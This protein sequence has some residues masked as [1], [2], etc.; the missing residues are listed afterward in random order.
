[1]KPLRLTIEG[2]HSFAQEQQIAF[3][4]LSDLGMFG[5]FGPTGSGKSSILDAITLA[6]YCDIPNG[7][8]GAINHT[9]KRMN[10]TF[11]FAIGTPHDRK[12]YIVYRSFQRGD[13]HAVRHHLSK[14]LEIDD[15]GGQTMLAEGKTS[16]TDAIEHIIGL[17]MADFTRAVVLPQGKFAEFLNLKSDKRTEMLE[18]IFALEQYG[19][20]FVAHVNKS[21]NGI[22]TELDMAR[23]ALFALGDASLEALR[24]A[25]KELIAKKDEVAAAFDGLNHAT[26]KKQDAEVIY[27]WQQEMIQ[28]DLQITDF[29]KLRPHIETKRAKLLKADRA[30]IVQPFIQAVVDATARERE[31]TQTLKESRAKLTTLQQE[32]ETATVAVVEAN[33]QWE[34]QSPDLF[35][36]RSR[37]MEAKLLEQEIDALATDLQQCEASYG[38]KKTKAAQDKGLLVSTEQRLNAA[39]SSL[40]DLERTLEDHRVIP[41]YRVKLLTASELVN[42]YRSQRKTLDERRALKNTRE[43][44]QSAASAAFIAATAEFE[45]ITADL[46]RLQKALDAALAKPHQTAEDIHALEITLNDLLH[47]TDQWAQAHRAQTQAQA[48]QSELAGLVSDQRQA[49]GR[50]TAELDEASRRRATLDA[51]DAAM[52]LAHLLIEGQPCPVCGSTS[53]PALGTVS[54]TDTRPDSAVGDERINDID[55]ANLNELNELIEN[56]QRNFESLKNEIYRKEAALESLAKQIESATSE[57]QRVRQTIRKTAQNTSMKIP[58]DL[59]DLLTWIRAQPHV[60]ALLKEGLRAREE[61]IDRLKNELTKTAQAHADKDRARAVKEADLAVKTT[62]LSSATALYEEARAFARAAYDRLLASISNLVDST[63]DTLDPVSTVRVA[64]ETIAKK[65]EKFHQAQQDIE[66]LRRD[67]LTL[68]SDVVRYK[69]QIQDA[70]VNLTRLQEEISHKTSLHDSKKSELYGITD[71]IPRQSALERASRALDTLAQARDSAQAAM[72]NLQQ[73]LSLA[74]QGVFSASEKLKDLSQDLQSRQE[75]L[76]QMLLQY[77][78]VTQEEVLDALL[79][80]TEQAALNQEVS[81]YDENLSRVKH[82]RQ[83]LQIALANQN[84]SEQQWADLQAEIKQANARYLGAL[85]AQGAAD[86][87]LKQVAKRHEKWIQTKVLKENLEQKFTRIQMLA[88]LFSGN[89]FIEFLSQEQMTWIARMASDKLKHLTRERYALLLRD[90]G[91]FLMRDDHNGSVLRPTTTLSGGETFL[92]SL[93]LA[94]SLS[95]QV[96][97]RGRYPLEFFFLDEGFGTLDPDLLDVVVG[98]LERLRSDRLTIGVISHVPELRQRMQRRLI[99]NA[100]EP[101]GKGTTI[102]VERA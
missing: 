11:E 20:G 65:D 74:N 82:R 51:R 61:H 44:E 32:A 73:A 45:Q 21:K 70:E 41:E 77:E 39:K 95:T 40:S 79:E 17:N 97:L 80:E 34:V 8:S 28:L 46:D 36:R 69:T 5:I 93:A 42:A 72:D 48:E 50:I 25:E 101:S 19:R 4:Q 22:A 54:V 53:H 68:E 24:A 71:G 63:H 67:M 7:L 10:V 26:K 49:L 33:Q 91:S 2:L 3:D 9:R 62:E 56:L 60:L 102:R 57:V 100:A 14:L 98:S 66:K 35:A 59:E 58:E 55:M 43:K 96:Q 47:A 76:K 12:R 90:D 64:Q 99:T 13:E 81:D 87:R 6:L 75:S 30:R 94:L 37:L 27:N 92:T 16:V 15:T 78:F 83:V 1:M 84:I 88:N 89:H 31:L 86:E 18:R 23:Q 38:E 52:R 85:E 29:D